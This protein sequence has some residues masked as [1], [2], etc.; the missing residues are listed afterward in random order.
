[1]GVITFQVFGLYIDELFLV[2]IGRE[3]FV[4]FT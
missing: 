3:I 2:S 1:M 4:N